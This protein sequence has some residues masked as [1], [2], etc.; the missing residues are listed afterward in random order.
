MKAIIYQ[1]YLEPIKGTD[2]RVAL[3]FGFEKPSIPSY[4]QRYVN[5]AL[6]YGR[7]LTDMRLLC[8]SL[9]LI[10]FDL[11]GSVVKENFPAYM[12]W[13]VDGH[14]TP[15]GHYKFAEALADKIMAMPYFQQLVA[16]RKAQAASPA[17]AH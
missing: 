2:S 6:D 11:S 12:R 1:E 9:G 14:L 13:E 4:G 15:T 5:I 3:V 10:P 17:P 8:E 16:E 7:W